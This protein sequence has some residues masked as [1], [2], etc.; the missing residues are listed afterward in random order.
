M[1]S[2]F[3]RSVAARALRSLPTQQSRLSHQVGCAFESQRFHGNSTRTSR[4]NFINFIGPCW[5]GMPSPA[6]DEHT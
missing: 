1:L 3:Y 2:A 5:D 6:R 4:L